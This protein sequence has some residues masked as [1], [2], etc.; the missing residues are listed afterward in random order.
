MGLMCAA[1]A[2]RAVHADLEGVDLVLQR[3]QQHAQ[4]RYLPRHLHS[5]SSQ[6]G[7]SWMHK[8]T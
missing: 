6:A 4:A 3:P 8:A 2:V 5:S 7:H 1:R